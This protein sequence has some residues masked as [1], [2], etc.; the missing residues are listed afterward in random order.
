MDTNVVVDDDD[1]EEEEADQTSGH[2][3]QSVHCSLGTL[4]D[5]YNTKTKVGGC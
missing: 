2:L 5:W 1:D 3:H 4:C